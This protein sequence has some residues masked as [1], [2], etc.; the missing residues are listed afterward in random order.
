MATGC[1]ANPRP[2]QDRMNEVDLPPPHISA[3]NPTDNTWAEVTLLGGPGCSPS[4]GL[5]SH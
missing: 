5:I 4:K 2:P 3:S 1:S